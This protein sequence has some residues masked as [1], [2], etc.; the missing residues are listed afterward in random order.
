MRRGFRMLIQNRPFLSFLLDIKHS[1]MARFKHSLLLAQHFSP[2]LPV[3]VP[4]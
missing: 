2:L 4:Q 1:L 3:R